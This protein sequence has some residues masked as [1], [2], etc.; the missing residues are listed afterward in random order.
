MVCRGAQR[1]ANSDEDVTRRWVEG[2]ISS[3]K[4][5]ASGRAHRN[6]QGDIW[7]LM[8]LLPT[9]RRKNNLLKGAWR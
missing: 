8:W 9:I 4:P 6:V 5:V 3:C 2:R 1:A 7:F